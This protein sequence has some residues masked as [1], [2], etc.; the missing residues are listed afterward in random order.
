MAANR[1][2]ASMLLALAACGGAVA[3]DASQS[4]D[5]SSLPSSSSS[6][7]AS[8]AHQST[9]ADHKAVHHIRVPDDDAAAPL[10]ELTEA[11][12][13]I[14]KQNYPEAESLLHKLLERDATSY[15]GW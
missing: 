7:S 8:G 4:P 9:S 11:E 6:S 3:Q 2:L 10:S 15:V 13:A 5:A 14:E 1:F 12:A